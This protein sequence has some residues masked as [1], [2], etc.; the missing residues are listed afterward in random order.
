MRVTLNWLKEFVDFDLTAEE[1]A[2]KFDLSGTAVESLV[3]LGARFDKFVV[4]EV[5]SVDKHPNADRLRLC[6]VSLNGRGADIVCGAP[7]VEAGQKVPVALPGAILPSG[8]QIKATRIRGAD[9]EGMICSA[10]ELELGSDVSGIMVLP[11][12]TEVGQPLALALGLDDWVLELEITPNRPDCMGMIG[13]AREVAALVGGVVRTPKIELEE[14]G[15]T[16]ESKAK[17]TIT[18]ADLCHRY[19]ARFVDRVTIGPSPGWMSRRLESVGIRSINNVVDVT[20]YVLLETGQPLHAFDFKL[21]QGGEIIVRRA[22]PGERLETIDHIERV[23]EP[24]HLVIADAG[25]AVALAGV[26]GGAYSE[27]NDETTEVLIESANFLAPNI[28]KTSRS[29]GLISESS[30]RFERGVDISGTAWAADRTAQL[31]AA[32]AGGRVWAGTIDVYPEPR[33]PRRVAVRPAR[34]NQVLGAEITRERMREIFSSLELAVEERPGKELEVT[35]PTFRVDL[36]REIDLIE[37]VARLYGLNNIPS[38]LLP[39]TDPD[40]GLNPLQSLTRSLRDLM[41]GAGLTEVVNYSFIGQAELDRLGLE[42]GHSWLRAAP[43][44]NPLSEDQGLMRTSLI[45]SLLRTVSHNYNRGQKDMRIFEIGNIFT[46]N[47]K[48]P[49][50]TLT[51]GCAL[52]GRRAPD[53]WQAPGDDMVDFYDVKGLIELCCQKLSLTD[54]HVRPADHPVLWPGQAAELVSGAGVIGFAGAIHPKVQENYDL[55]QPVYIFQANIEALLAQVR[56]GG[57]FS[58]IPRFPAVDLD[59]ALIVDERVNWE[60][61]RKLALDVGAPLLRQVRLFDLYRGPGV[62]P[63]RKSLAFNLTYQADDRTLTDK[64]VEHIQA[65]ILKRAAAELG[66]ELR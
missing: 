1:L 57:G 60:N 12:E 4:G 37:E 25:R 46:Q 5:V 6:K 66:A 29:L 24:E 2:D 30:L 27:I 13:V 58:E 42:P 55:R 9:S 14:A 28:R 39:S 59:L 54:C 36:E 20:N 65:R 16:I 8:L 10:N 35:V 19:S 7:N 48:P 31:I 18:D 53:D 3:H 33:G 62:P 40:R 51:L 32:T 21:L 47:E 22:T 56:A 44:V 43:I 38:A 34:V 61:I 41:V 23:L 63:G 52:T 64:E 11:P 15:E 49:A 17:I 45:S 26:M 50:Q